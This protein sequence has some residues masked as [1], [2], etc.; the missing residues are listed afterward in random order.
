MPFKLPP[1]LVFCSRSPALKSWFLIYE[2]LKKKSKFKEK[3]ISTLFFFVRETY[4]TERFFVL[5]CT[6]S[7]KLSFN[8]NFYS[9][10]MQFDTTWICW[11]QLIKD[12]PFFTR[13]WL[14][15]ARILCT[16][17]WPMLQTLLW[18]EF[19]QVRE[20]SPTLEIMMDLSFPLS[21]P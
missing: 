6:V 21:H 14:R 3:R 15:R 19:S 20:C 11:Q 10:P 17:P 16:Q 9:S 7:L 1:D 18:I 13:R 4:R 8:C 2:E 5:C 12:V